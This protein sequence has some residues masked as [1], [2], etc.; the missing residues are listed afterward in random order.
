MSVAHGFG[1]K[2]ISVL[3]WATPRRFHAEVM[4]NTMSAWARD[5]KESF[6]DSKL[7]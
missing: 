6:L 5:E 2:A 3:T 7:C 4:A 1:K